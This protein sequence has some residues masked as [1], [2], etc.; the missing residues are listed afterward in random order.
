MRIKNVDVTVSDLTHQIAM[1]SVEEHL[2]KITQ[3]PS[4]LKDRVESDLIRK[5]TSV[6]PD[7]IADSSSISQDILVKHNGSPTPGS[8]QSKARWDP[9]VLSTHQNEKKS[10]RFLERDKNKKNHE[11]SPKRF[12]SKIKVSTKSN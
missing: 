3:L 11:K 2:K 6:K 4:G 8:W 5:I 10:I 9:L 12:P 7:P 1:E